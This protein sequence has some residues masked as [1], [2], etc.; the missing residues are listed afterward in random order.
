MTTT[1][2]TPAMTEALAV[3]ATQGGVAFAGR[4]KVKGRGHVKV[5]AS[6]LTA[7]EARGLAR[8]CPS[9]DGGYAVEII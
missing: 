1:N 4:N 6:T 8:R 7:L 9:A 2:I 3:A 5:D